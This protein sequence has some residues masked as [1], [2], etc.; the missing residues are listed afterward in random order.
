MVAVIYHDNRYLS[1]INIPMNPYFPPWLFIYLKK[2]K[3]ASWFTDTLEGKFSFL[4]AAFGFSHKPK[5]L[6]SQ[7]ITKAAVS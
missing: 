5:L 7:R 3:M 4:V 6:F 1:V 2:K